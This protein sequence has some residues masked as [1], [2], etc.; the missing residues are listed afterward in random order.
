MI[1]I[2]E[3]GRKGILHAETRAKGHFFAGIILDNEIFLGLE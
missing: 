1:G 3:A 2:G